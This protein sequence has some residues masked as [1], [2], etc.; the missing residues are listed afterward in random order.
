MLRSL[1]FP[2]LFLLYPL[3]STAQPP[4]E[5]RRRPHKSWFKGLLNSQN[6][7]CMAICMYLVA[8][9]KKCFYFDQREEMNKVTDAI[10]TLCLPHF[11]ISCDCAA[12]CLRLSLR[13]YNSFSDIEYTGD[14]LTPFN[15]CPRCT[16]RLS[17]HVETSCPSLSVWSNQGSW[18]PSCDDVNLVL[19]RSGS[20]DHAVQ[21]VLKLLLRQLLFDRSRGDVFVSHFLLHLVFFSYHLRDILLHLFTH[22]SW[23]RF[24]FFQIYIYICRGRFM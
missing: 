22:F 24:L 11:S 2:K 10:K 5:L 14:I 7:Y 19:A 8:L 12:S 20:G 16:A 1:F 17:E 4:R 13:T 3:I 21:P 6:C 15:V 23:S 18:G 9:I